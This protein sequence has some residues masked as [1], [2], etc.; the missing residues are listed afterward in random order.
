MIIN[1]AGYG[2]SLHYISKHPSAILKN[3]ISMHLNIY[4]IA[5]KLKKKPKIIN[6]LCNCS[7]PGGKKIQKENEWDT[8]KVHNSV[9]VPG[10]IHRLRQ[11]ISKASFE[12][13]KNKSINLLIGGFIWTW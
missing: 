8:N 5:E 10:N 12:E 7:Y 13:C 6:I 3:D 4:K 1:C 11:I 9:Y 2:F